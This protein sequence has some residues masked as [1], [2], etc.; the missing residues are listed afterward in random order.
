MAEKK[1]NLVALLTRGLSQ[2]GMVR[3]QGEGDGGDKVRGQEGC[4][5]EIRNWW[6]SELE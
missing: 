2:L 4:T 1:E 6:I 3:P 5:S